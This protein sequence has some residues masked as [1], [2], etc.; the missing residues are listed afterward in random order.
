[1]KIDKAVTIARKAAL[2]SNAKFRVGTCLFFND[3]Y[4]FGY[5]RNFGVK[6][7]GR[8]KPF[9]VHAEEMAIVKA[10]RIIN[11][12]FKNST[13]VVV[14]INKGGKLMGITPCSYCQGMINKFEIKT[15]YCSI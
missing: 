10:N 4:V 13:L 9:S 1:M 5:N 6:S 3:T 14:R 11:F 2:N 8:Q 12:D 15:V 7:I